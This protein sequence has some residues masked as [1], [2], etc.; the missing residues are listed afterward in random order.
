M[1]KN[2]NYIIQL[3]KGLAAKGITPS[4]GM[5]RSKSDRPL[6]MPEIIQVLK[7]WKEAGEE[8]AES[9]NTETEENPVP[10]SLEQ[11]VD[12]LEREVRRL[13]DLL[14]KHGINA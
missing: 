2:R 6:Q 8:L 13:T 12:A 11:R 9:T 10:Q 4:V 7:Q 5:I 14:N 3:C 1:S